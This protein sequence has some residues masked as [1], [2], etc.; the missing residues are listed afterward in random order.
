MQHATTF[1]GNCAVRASILIG[2]ADNLTW[3]EM[4][5]KCSGLIATEPVVNAPVLFR[6][7]A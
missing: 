4:E 1:A 3:E 2:S 6:G 5:A 7:N